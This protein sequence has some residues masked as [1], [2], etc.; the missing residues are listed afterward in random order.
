[1]SE[2]TPTH[3]AAILACV[4]AAFGAG[5]LLIM[6]MAARAIGTI[7]VI[8]YEKRRHVYYQA[9]CSTAPDVSGVEMA[10]I[11]GVTLFAGTLALLGSTWAGME[12]LE[13][14]ARTC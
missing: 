8:Q 13:Y 14:F 5:Y 3:I 9:R 12:M 11:I 6:R 1:M 4:A 2:M 10:V 7:N